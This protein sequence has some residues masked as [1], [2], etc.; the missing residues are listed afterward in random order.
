MTKTIIA[1]VAVVLLVSWSAQA[2]W[3]WDDV[4][5]GAR[6]TYE[7][8]T[9][10]K[11]SLTNAEVI[12]GLKEALTIGA[13]KAAT[14]ASKL[15]GFYGNPLIKIPFPPEANKVKNAAMKMGM[16]AQVKKFVKTLNRAAEE[17]AKEAAP[18]FVDA[19]KGLTIQDGFNIL[20]GPDDAA[21][22]YLKR[23]T[24]PRLKQ[25]FRP[26][27]K[28]AIDKVQVTK[29]WNPIATNYN[30]M[31]FVTKV[32][33]DLDAYVTD[34][35]IKGLFTLIAKE[36]KKIRKDPAARVTELLRRVFGG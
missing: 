7:S 5:R 3:N 15:N 35:A 19:I 24:T 23:K 9:G 30:R 29:Y 10:R 8:A 20:N 36:E 28:R 14:S 2:G 16:D 33:P 22:K 31:P 11:G 26:V 4:K 27:V 12:R 13:K 1:C 25:K 32:N 21:T 6:Q 18:I 17:A 34:R